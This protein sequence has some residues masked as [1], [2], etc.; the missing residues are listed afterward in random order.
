M[1]KTLLLYLLLPSFFMSNKVL[2]QSNDSTLIEFTNKLGVSKTIKITNRTIELGESDTEKMLLLSRGNGFYLKL[3]GAY[4]EQGAYL[5]LPFN[6][7]TEALLKENIQEITLN[8][9]K[10]IKGSLL[11]KIKIDGNSYDLSSMSTLKVLKAGKVTSQPKYYDIPVKNDKLWTLSTSLTDFSDLTITDPRFSYVYYEEYK[12]IQLYPPN[13]Y[14]LK[15]RH[16]VDFT[17]SFTVKIENDEIDANLIDFSKLTLTESDYYTSK[18]ELTAKNNLK[19]LGTFRIRKGDKSN[20]GWA[21]VATIKDMGDATLLMRNPN[22]SI[23]EK[24]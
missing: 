8:T 15:T 16:A 9:G 3:E 13:T 1:K 18:I 6:F 20:M 4:L 14:I 12:E 10:V 7:F 17:R 2:S 11:G 24:K 5:I 22:I 19:T 21:F 23:T